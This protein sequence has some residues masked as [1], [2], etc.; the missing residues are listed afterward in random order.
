VR[1]VRHCTCRGRRGDFIARNVGSILYMVRWKGFRMKR[2]SRSPGIILALLS[3]DSRKSRKPTISFPFRNSKRASPESELEPVPTHQV[4]RYN[5]RLFTLSHSHYLSILFLL[6]HSLSLPPSVPSSSR[7]ASKHTHGVF[8]LINQL[9]N[10][11]DLGAKVMP[12]IVTSPHDGRKD[13][14]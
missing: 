2:P 11:R 9:T 14:G 4:P 13:R 7:K 1:D 5:T 12:L 10:F 3:R 6:H 8:H